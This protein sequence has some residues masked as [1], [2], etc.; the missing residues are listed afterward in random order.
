MEEKL[1]FSLPP[2]KQKS[3]PIA[4]IT[5][6]LLLILVGLALANLFIKPPSQGHPAKNADL[7]LSSEQVRHLAAKLAGRNLYNRAAK[8]WQ[9]YLSGN[10]LPDIERAKTLFQIATLLEKA[11]AYAEAIEYYYRSEI[12]A[13]LSE[14]EPQINTHIKNC[15]EKLGKFS[16][17]RYELMDRT[18]FKKAEQAGGKI[19]AEIGAEKITEADLDALIERTIDNQLAPMTAFMTANQLNEQKK[20]ILDQYKSPSAKQQFLESWLTQEVLYRQALEEKLSEQ[21]EAKSAIEDLVRTALSRQLMNREISD[22]INI[23]ENDLQT[24]YQA[25]KE[26]YI[27]PAKA[28]ISHILAESRQQAN[29]LIDRLK[30][31]DDFGELAG[32]LSTDQNTKE[33]G[34]KIDADIRKGSYVPVIGEFKELNEKIF[35]TD[36][37][38]VLAEPFKTEMG[39]EVI[40]VRERHAERQKSFDEVKQQVITALLGQKRQDVQT[41]LIKKMMDKYNVIVHTSV[42]RGTEEAETE[43]SA[44]VPIKK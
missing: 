16:A 40:N 32:E 22:K 42:L 19:V 5:V 10:K 13:K 34:G 41:D 14:L 18:S 39:W 9:D 38:K 6:L 44:S 33:N 43:E 21:P 12:T 7:S 31:G 27:E 24:Y 36:A 29:D 15:F 23:T 17:L 4:K 2:K 8:V 11:D 20:K 3:S 28:R 1:D 37:G 35:A 25:N 26:I 30:N